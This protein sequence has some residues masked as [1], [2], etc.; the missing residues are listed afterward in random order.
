M[1]LHVSPC[2]AQLKPCGA[3]GRPR[4]VL[5]HTVGLFSPNEVCSCHLSTQRECVCV[6]VV[7]CWGLGWMTV[8]SLACVVVETPHLVNLNEDP[9]M[10]ECLLYYIKDGLTR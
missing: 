10:S 9:L 8:L 1:V 5:I 3:S 7:V 6:C 4:P 2:L